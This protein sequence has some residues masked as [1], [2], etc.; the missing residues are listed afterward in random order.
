MR[1]QIDFDVISENIGNP[2]EKQ[3]LLNRVHQYLE[4]GW[5]VIGTHVPQTGNS[6]ITI[7]V[8]LGKYEEVA[9][10]IRKVKSDAK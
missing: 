10:E 3:R 5:E 8:A 6:S 7:T 2:A 9:D 4:D 1:K